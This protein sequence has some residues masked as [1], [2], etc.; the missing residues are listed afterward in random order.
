MSA[1]FNVYTTTS[2]T[3]GSTY[4]RVSG[5]KVYLRKAPSIASRG[6]GDWYL[7]KEIDITKGAKFSELGAEYQ[8]WEAALTETNF[9]S[10]SGNVIPADNADQIAINNFPSVRTY[11][12]ESGSGNEDIITVDGYKTAVI[13]N[14]MAY[15]GHVKQDSIVYGDRVLKSNINKFDR[16]PASRKLEASVNDGD[17][18]VK[19]EA[20]AD[21]LLI[22]KKNKLELLNISQEVEFLEDTFMHKGVSHPAATCKTDFGIAWVNR[23]GCYLYDGQKVNNLLEK[24][25][26]QIIK[27]SEWFNFLT[28]AK[29]GS[30]TIMTPMIGYLPKKRQLIVFDDITNNS[31]ANPRMYLYD[32]VTQSWTKGSNDG[33]NRVIDIAKTNFITDW[34]GD[35]VYAHTAGTVVKWDD[36]GDDSTAFV[37]T[38][39][40][41]DFGNPAQKKKVYKVYVT[42]TGVSSLDVD[43]E[44]RTNG[45]GSWTAVQSGSTLDQTSGQNEA[46]LTLST[47]VECYS[48]QLKFSGTGKTTFEIN[49]A[50]I[51]FRLK[52]MR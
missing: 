30:G 43:V 20:Y 34:N 21:R 18:I 39:K 12:S 10:V 8:M 5:F 50:T 6:T 3:F 36:A 51:V 41:I 28:P 52:G 47:P 32:M 9:A 22:F 16:F 15:I 44:Y 48:F 25:G 49:D 23:Q 35:L 2:N 19:L 17:S 24:V 33:S 14:R 38:T 46:T 1:R 13:A 4:P 42:Y 27:E 29:D 26:R 37:I 7:W 45:D 40:D 31:T 11:A